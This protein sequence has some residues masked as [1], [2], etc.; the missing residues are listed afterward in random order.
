VSFSVLDGRYAASLSALSPIVGEENFVY[1]M[2]LWSLT[3]AEVLNNDLHLPMYP[4]RQLLAKRVSVKEQVTK[5]QMVAL[6]QVLEEDYPEVSFHYGLT[7][8][9]IMH[10]AR[11]TQVHL[12]ILM[13]NDLLREVE[14][15]I[16]EYEKQLPVA[17][18]AHTHGQPA[19]P[20]FIGPYLRAKCRRIGL[21]LP[22]Y[23]LG[24]S[25][26]QLTALR[27]I[28]GLS[29]FKDMATAW[30][31]K[32]AYRL[33]QLERVQIVTPTDTHGLLQLGPS[34]EATLLSGV[35]TAV[36]MRALARALWDHCQRKLLLYE[37]S[38]G[39]AGSS[40]MP[41][42]VNPIDFEN[43]EGAF[44]IAEKTLLTA[45][46]A[47]SDTRGL[48]D[49]SNSII[50]RQML[51]GWVY[52]Y[53]GLKSLTRGMSKTIYSHERA[54]GEL[55]ENPEC[56]TEILRYYLQEREGHADPYW[57]LKQN[58]PTDFNSTMERLGPWKDFLVRRR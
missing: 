14:L 48:R 47:N 53:H 55:R 25:N 49:L 16:R 21:V 56:L 31:K 19:T 40:A 7:S 4:D 12:C 26:G 35:A 45:F 50:N 36:K 42:K 6:I 5:H 41:H 18:L 8:E 54:V 37:S 17:I 20:V 11:W 24:G 22:E 23:R 3:Y 13:I 46:E 52:L 38:S 44:T 15:A 39:Q 9:D 28:S 57:E 43:A 10:N 32:V 33:A 1:F 27:L 30:S 2:S 58:P 29:D 51:E 34:N